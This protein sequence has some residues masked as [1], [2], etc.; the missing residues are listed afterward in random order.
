MNAATT[1][2]SVATAKVM[3]EVWC[4]V[5]A[6]RRYRAG[7]QNTIRAG[8][9]WPLSWTLQLEDRRWRI[10]ARRP[11][12]GDFADGHAAQRLGA[13]LIRHSDRGF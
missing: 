2:L 12:I 5:A 11:A 7:K 10:T 6:Q 3:K 9:I 4:R 13:G 1:T 8:Y